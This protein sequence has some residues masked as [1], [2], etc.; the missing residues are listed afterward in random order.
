MAKSSFSFERNLGLRLN[1][2]EQERFDE[3]KKTYEM[4]FEGT[5]FH[6][7]AMSDE[8]FIRILVRDGIERIML[9][10]ERMKKAAGIK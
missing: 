6:G 8:H 7:L 4:A 9:P 1:S 3:A 2:L 5:E 10:I